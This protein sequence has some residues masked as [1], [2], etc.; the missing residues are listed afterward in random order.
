MK[1]LWFVPRYFQIDRRHV[2][3]SIT[4]VPKKCGYSESDIMI[5]VVSGRLIVKSV[6]DEQLNTINNLFVVFFSH[7]AGFCADGI[8]R[9]YCI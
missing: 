3:L 1:G 9:R 8:N 5:T 4:F 2:R 7:D 6:Y